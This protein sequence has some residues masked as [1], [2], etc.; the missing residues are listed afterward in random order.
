MLCD[1][2]LFYPS[3]SPNTIMSDEKKASYYSKAIMAEPQVVE[4]KATPSPTPSPE[5]SSTPYEKL[6]TKRSSMARIQSMRIRTKRKQKPLPGDRIYK[7]CCRLPLVVK[8]FLVTV[9][10]GLPFAVFL[11]LSYTTYSGHTIGDENNFR[12]C[13]PNLC[14]LS[15]S[16]SRHTSAHGSIAPSPKSYRHKS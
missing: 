6:S 7:A 16:C 12:T 2:C 3:L 9:L 13:L 1:C 5:L 14:R 8:A 11:G 15:L 10:S 4:R